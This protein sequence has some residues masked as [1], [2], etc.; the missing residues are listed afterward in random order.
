M[1]LDELTGEVIVN[2]EQQL[3]DYSV[4]QNRNYES[5][6]IASAA[7]FV[8]GCVTGILAIDYEPLAFLTGTVT[9]MNAGFLIHSGLQLFDNYKKI[10]CLEKEIRDYDVLNKK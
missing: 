10:N 7:T 5:A 8:S 1:T 2:R 6:I 4:T 3:K 9:L